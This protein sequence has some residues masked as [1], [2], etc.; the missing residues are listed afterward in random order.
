[1]LQTHNQK[2]AGPGPPPNVLGAAEGHRRMAEAGQPSQTSW[3]RC[4]SLEDA[5][6]GKCSKRPAA[7]AARREARTCRSRACTV[8]CPWLGAA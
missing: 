7:S 2:Q 3:S 6:A 4:V 8:S 1:M 5:W